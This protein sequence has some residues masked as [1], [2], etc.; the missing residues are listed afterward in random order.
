MNKIVMLLASIA[1]V[2]ATMAP[3]QADTDPTFAGSI[4]VVAGMG[5]GNSVYVSQNRCCGGT[6][7]GP[8]R[9]IAPGQSSKQYW[10]DTDA[11]YLA[12]GY[13]LVYGWHASWGW[14]A[15]GRY[16]STGWHNLDRALYVWYVRD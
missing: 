16:T 15:S 2:F 10:P 8:Y 1:L 12:S 11:F 9:W 14:V 7:T 5:T 4:N 13:D 3:V 6:A